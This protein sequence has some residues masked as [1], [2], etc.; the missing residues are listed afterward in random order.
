MYGLNQNERMFMEKT[1]FIVSV[2]YREVTQPQQYHSQEAEVS[3]Q[4]AINEDAD[5]EKAIEGG[6]A[7]VKRQVRIAL[8]KEA[9]TLTAV[10]NDPA[11]RG[12][13]RP[14]KDKLTE[15]KAAEELKAKAD[16]EKQPETAKVEEK[17]NPT[18]LPSDDDFDDTAEDKPKEITDAE[19][20]EACRKAVNDGKGAIVAADVKNMARL[21]YGTDKV[22]A[23]KQ[24]EREKFIADLKNLVAE[25]TKK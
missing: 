5:A 20:Q 2:R 11:K 17:V 10:A 25:K 18:T 6:L 1:P 13:G 16:P 3:S 21:K 4:Y 14:P 12:P 15:Q 7:M 19:V 9:G 23:I 8:G 24:E 22:V